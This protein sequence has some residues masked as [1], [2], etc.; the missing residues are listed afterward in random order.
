MIS[1][2]KRKPLLPFFIGERESQITSL[3]Y[4]FTDLN[5]ICPFI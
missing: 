4:E 1:D 2:D 3:L 5:F